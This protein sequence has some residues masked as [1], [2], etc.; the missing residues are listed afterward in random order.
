MEEKIRLTKEGYIK[1]KKELDH[2]I[3][4]RR[5]EIA[6]RIGEGIYHKRIGDKIKVKTPQREFKYEIMEIQ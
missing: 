1:L 5:L 3:K 4:N 2:L 6:R